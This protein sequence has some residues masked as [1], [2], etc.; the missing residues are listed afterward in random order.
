M[1]GSE[2]VMPSLTVDERLDAIEKQ[3]VELKN[4]I[5]LEMRLLRGSVQ[6]NAR[7]R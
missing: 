2:E 3:L 1:G 6:Q 5:K 7:S 4:T